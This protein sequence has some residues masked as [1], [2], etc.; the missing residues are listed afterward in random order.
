MGMKIR[1][2][3]APTL[4]KAL[5]EIRQEMG[6]G[7]IILQAD[8]IK[9]GRFGRNAV[10]VTA[11]IEREDAIPRF[12][13]QLTDGDEERELAQSQ[14]AK[15]SR[16]LF[17]GIFRGKAKK[18][19]KKENKKSEQVKK[20]VKEMKV[21]PPTPK[22]TD[23]PTAGQVFAMKSYL[24]P[25]QKEIRQL[26]ELMN[27]EKAKAGRVPSNSLIEAEIQGLKKMF[28]GYVNDQKFSNESLSAPMRKLSNFWKEKGMSTRQIHGF[29]DRIEAE[30]LR[31]DEQSDAAMMRPLLGRKIREGKNTENP[32]QKIIC[33]IGPT[34]VGK[35]TTIA[36]LAAFEKLKLNRSSALV[37]LD[38]YKIGGTDQLSHFARIL[39]VPF[40]KARSDLNLEEQIQHL[41]VDTLF[42]DTFGV[43]PR[44][45]KKMLE[46]RKSLN[47]KD[48]ALRARTERH[49]VL[50]VGVASGDIDQILES[51][52]RLQPDYL[53]FTKWDETENWGG[54]LATILESQTPV[55]FVGHGQ[56]VPDD[57]SVFSA[58]SFVETV[59]GVE[60]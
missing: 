18:E 3:K 28:A 11:A 43:A 47:F 35:T 13:I 4:Q 20:A 17:S 21:A 19:K 29:F 54:M 8:P 42:I 46:I 33:L 32:K 36:K 40:I 57:I 50:P 22:K 23:A 31:F 52:S 44:D 58:Q 1:K 16:G 25:L 9:D 39:E 45:E 24:E 48:P 51:F 26:K 15:S 5:E 30:G 41:N 59:M 37:T 49:L 12:N 27:M 53:I 2:F 60:K 34:G 7:A 55:S 6:D 38:D 14:E 10:E 56:E